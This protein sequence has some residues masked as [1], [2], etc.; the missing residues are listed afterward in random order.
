MFPRPLI[1]LFA[2]IA[3][4]PWLG[5]AYGMSG[6]LLAALVTYTS[7]SSFRRT[8]CADSPARRW[9]RLPTCYAVAGS[10]CFAVRIV[11]AAPFAVEGFVAGNIGIKLRDFLLGTFLG[12]L[13]G[14]LT[15][16]V[17]GDQIQTALEDPSRI[18]WWLV[19]GVLLM[20]VVMIL[21]REA[22]VREA[23]R[24]ASVALTLS[25]S[26]ASSRGAR[27]NPRTRRRH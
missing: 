1:T 17:F 3:F 22:V 16:T 18:N 27:M 15:T 7:A 25:A 5:F 24:K 13:P 14:T 2:V 19:A 26:F 9:I 11:P 6:I 12:M 4:G 23:E 10:R 20:F 8:R 21:L